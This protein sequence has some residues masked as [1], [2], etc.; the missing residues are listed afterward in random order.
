MLLGDFIQSIYVTIAGM[1]MVFITLGGL[2]LIIAG[3]GR[4]FREP[5][6]PAAPSLG[7]DSSFS[8]PEMEDDPPAEVVAAIAVALA[9]LKVRETAPPPPKTTVVTLASGTSAWKS[10]GRLS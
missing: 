2:M 8:A 5:T 6:A 9:A 7:G 4:V 3:L 10:G 1:T